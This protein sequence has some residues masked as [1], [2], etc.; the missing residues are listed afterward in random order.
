MYFWGLV[1]NIYFYVFGK[2]KDDLK[3]TVIDY[4][5]IIKISSTD[6]I[7][8]SYEMQ[9]IDNKND[10][11]DKISTNYLEDNKMI[12]SEILDMESEYSKDVSSK[13]SIS[14]M[15]SES[16]SE[17]TPGYNYDLLSSLRTEEFLNTEI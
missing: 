16:V 1:K 11:E 7:I 13:E 8:Y 6:K 17:L 14:E 12:Y 9:H 15:N 10:C 3:K 5:D 4:S 2:K